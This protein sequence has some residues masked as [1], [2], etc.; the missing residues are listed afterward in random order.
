[1]YALTE[2]A[3]WPGVVWCGVE[4]MALCLTKVSSA[5]SRPHFHPRRHVAASMPLWQRP[6]LGGNSHCERKKRKKSPTDKA[7]RQGYFFATGEE[8]KKAHMTQKEKERNKEK[9]RERR[10]ESEC[11]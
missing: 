5:P 1:M 8:K 6:P 4:G 2:M 10:R 9:K 3:A 7:W 11:Y